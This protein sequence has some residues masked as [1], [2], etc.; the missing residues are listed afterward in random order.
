VQ[1]HPDDE[2]IYVVRGFPYRR[3]A[4]SDAG[5]EA[6]RGKRAKAGSHLSEVGYRR[7]DL[8]INRDTVH[9]DARF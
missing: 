2:L 3:A 4:G 1:I 7:G 6:N 5:V 8:K 9:G